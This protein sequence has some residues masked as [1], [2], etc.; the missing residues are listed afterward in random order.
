MVGRSVCCFDD[1]A[2]QKLLGVLIDI[3]GRELELAMLLSIVAC[4]PASLA[5]SCCNNRAA[6][7]AFL[8]SFF[9]SFL[10]FLASGSF[11]FSTSL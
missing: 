3:C 5:S 2:R 6:A 9:S 11:S 8:F 7:F 10:L 4:R 1:P